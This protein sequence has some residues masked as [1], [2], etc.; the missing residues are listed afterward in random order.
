MDEDDH[1]LGSFEKK[2]HQF[3]SQKRLPQ[4]WTGG[5]DLEGPELVQMW[6]N[7]LVIEKPPQLECSIRRYECMERWCYNAEVPNEF[8]IKVSE[9]QLLMDMKLEGDQSYSRTN[10]IH[11]WAIAI[12]PRVLDGFVLITWIPIEDLKSQVFPSKTGFSLEQRFGQERKAGQISILGVLAHTPV[13]S[14]Q[15]WW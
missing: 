5:W 8:P 14:S 1:L 2:L 6:S 11:L 15:S 3:Q 13:T 4:Q 7:H 9:S 10:T 12:A